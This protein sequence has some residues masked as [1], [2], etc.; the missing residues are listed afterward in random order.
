MTKLLSEILSTRGYHEPR[1]LHRGLRVVRGEP[2][3]QQRLHSEMALADLA[4]YCWGLSLFGF[5]AAPF[6]AKERTR[7]T[8]F[9]RIFSGD[10]SPSPPII[11]PLPLLMIKKSSPS[12]IF[13]RV[14]GSR[15]S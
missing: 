10:R 14:E 9:Q 2:L 5:S 11:F 3:P 13:S 12:V 8:R 15:Q 4:G 6:F 7:F 1:G